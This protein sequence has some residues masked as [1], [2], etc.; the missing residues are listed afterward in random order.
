M[1]PDIVGAS[2]SRE[3]WRINP[4]ISGGGYFF[5][6]AC[7]QLDIL[8]FLFG[9]IQDAHGFACNQADMYP[10]EDIVAGSFYFGKGIYGPGSLVFYHFENFGQGTDYHCRQ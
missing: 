5:D 2:R 9:P 8:D 4:E 10:A 6:L 7:H 1:Q 3:N